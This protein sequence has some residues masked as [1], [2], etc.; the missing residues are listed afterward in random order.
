LAGRF[1]K[2]P[3]KLSEATLCEVPVEGMDGPLTRLIL[4]G[5]PGTRRDLSLVF[6]GTIKDV[7][8]RQA[9]TLRVEAHDEGVRITFGK[10]FALVL[11]A[12]AGLSAL[13]IYL[14]LPE[15]RHG[16]AAGTFAAKRREPDMADRRWAMLYEGEVKKRRFRS[17]LRSHLKTERIARWDSRALWWSRAGETD[18]VRVMEVRLRRD[19]PSRFLIARTTKA[20]AITFTACKDALPELSLAAPSLLCQAIAATAKH[21]VATQPQHPFRTKVGA[22]EVSGVQK[23]A[24]GVLVHASTYAEEEFVTLDVALQIVEGKPKV[25]RVLAAGERFSVE[26]ARIET[27]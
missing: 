24:Q 10:G 18:N 8:A 4:R 20:G 12:Q 21:L 15:E 17:A 19:G 3:W 11:D 6:E 16:F 1:Q 5:E 7:L 23:G 2:H 26:K 13:G 9:K 22:L 25:L 27:R 14:C